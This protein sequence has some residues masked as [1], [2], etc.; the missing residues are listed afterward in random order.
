MSFFEEL[1]RRNVFRVGIAYAVIGWVLAQV[2]ELAFDSFGA[3][4]WVM[5]SVLVVLLIGLP[6]A[7]FFARA[8]EIT[9]VGVKREKDVDRDASITKRTGRKLDRMIIGVLVVAVGLLLADR[10]ILDTPTDTDEVAETAG[11]Q[12]I[13]VLPFANMSEDNDHFSDGLTEELLNLLARIPDLKVAARTSSFAFKGQNDDLREIGDAL[14][15]D[16]VLEGSVRRSGD[17][18]RITAQL[19][20][21]EDG[22]HVWSETYDREL[23]DFFDIQDDVA[24]AI[25]DSMQLQLVSGAERPTNNTDAYAY[26]IEALSLRNAEQTQDLTTAQEL[27]DKAIELDP[28]FARA[29]EL[30]ASFYWLSG[31]WIIDAGAAQLL[32]HDS[33]TKALELDPSLVIARAFSA[34]ADPETWTWIQ[35]IEA[36][37]ELGASDPN[38]AIGL[39]ALIYVL[40]YTG[41]FDDALAVANR[42]IEVEPLSGTGYWR[43]GEALSAAGRKEEA[44]ESFLRA[45]ELG[46]ISSM[47]ALG[48]LACLDGNAEEAISWFE[49]VYDATGSDSTEIR[50]IVE[51]GLDAADGKAFIDAIVKRDTSRATNLDELRFP[52]FWYLS[53][54]YVDDYWAAIDLL[55]DPSGEQAWT[56]SDTLEHQGIVSNLSAFRQHPKYLQYAE[57]SSVVDLW[58]KRGAPDHC[59]KDSGEWI[60]R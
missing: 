9:P 5:K 53:F 41:Y 57:V 6:L 44:R 4:A 14:G 21:V 10:F 24:S 32:V 54:G 12:S 25:T 22:F 50:S 47:W 19:I 33:A 51:N 34:T 38:F 16:H 59:N 46:D 29:Y 1:K 35:E 56:N 45:V 52:Y 13:A 3:P 40:V 20:K 30:K 2:A 43:R 8:F 23:A 60:C 39:S 42:Y 28:N 17:R 31:G 48:M 7:L 49:G 55:G 58:E 36:L 18:I 15:V 11:R 37:E 27:L 26:Y